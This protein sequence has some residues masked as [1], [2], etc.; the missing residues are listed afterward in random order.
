MEPHA[1]LR[2]VAPDGRELKTYQYGSRQV[3]RP[4]IA[5]LMTHLMEGV[6]DRGTGAGVRA[7]GFKLPAAGKTGTSRDGWFVG[8]T[9]DLL[10]IAWVGFDDNRDLSLEGARS[11]LPIWTEFMLKAYQLYPVRDAGGM[12]FI[13]PRGIE[14]VTIDANTLMRAGPSDQETFEEAFIEGT[15]PTL[16]SS[17][18]P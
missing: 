11:A 2:V 1:L 9:K 8:Y 18:E 4:E 13:P 5:Y 12:S 14:I 15:A 6:I 7:R 3:L 16:V 17:I 10:V